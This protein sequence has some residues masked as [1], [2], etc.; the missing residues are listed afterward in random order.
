MNFE[1]AKILQKSA[2]TVSDR[3]NSIEANSPKSP[4]VFKRDKCEKTRKEMSKFFTGFWSK[5]EINQ[6]CSNGMG[7]P[8]EE[9]KFKHS[10]TTCKSDPVRY[11]E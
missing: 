2:L 1:K 10:V 8:T 3:R 11:G 4:K 9:S 5:A 6:M 7:S